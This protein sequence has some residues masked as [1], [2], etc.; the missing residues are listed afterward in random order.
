MPSQD[1]HDPP[2]MI[3]VKRLWIHGFLAG[4]AVVLILLTLSYFILGWPLG[5]TP[6]GQEESTMAQTPTTPPASSDQAAA[7][8]TAAAVGNPATLKIELEAVLA[9]LVEANRHKDLAGLLSL[10]DPAFPDLPQKAEEISRTWKIYDYHSLH[11]RIE[12]IRSQSPDKVT[13]RVIWEAEIRNRA[14]QELRRVTLTY[15]AGFSNGSG[16]WLICSLE[17][18]GRPPAQDKS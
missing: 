14:T 3:H 2:L 17:K 18:T 5:T 12:D 7:N 6:Q 9:R 4:L 15:L 13:A 16:H 8:Q 11:F 1:F 10:Y